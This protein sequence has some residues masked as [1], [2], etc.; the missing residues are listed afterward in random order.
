MN[1]FHADEI[2]RR[3]GFGCGLTCWS[4]TGDGAGCG[5]TGS[6]YGANSGISVDSR[7]DADGFSPHEKTPG[8]GDPLTVSIILSI[9]HQLST[10][11]Q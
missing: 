9:N 10:I 5:T 11:N 4:Y 7:E 3:G 8:H 1:L 6:I 2:R